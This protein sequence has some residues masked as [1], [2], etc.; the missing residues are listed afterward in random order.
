MGRGAGA[1]KDPVA[2]RSVSPIGSTV[3]KASARRA[4]AS[5]E[6]RD[7]QARLAPYEAIARL[8]IKRRQELGL[9]QQQ[10]AE[11]MGTSNTAISRI[12]SGRF[13]TRPETLARL[14]KALEMNYVHGFETGP[15]QKPKRHLV[16]VPG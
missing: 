6:Y 16:G 15:P 9:S 7:E 10:V 1:Q 2:E 12:E 5:K 4:R 14:A 13:G 11:R 8:V 3:A